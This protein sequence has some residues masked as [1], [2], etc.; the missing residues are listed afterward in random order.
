MFD[1]FALSLSHTSALTKRSRGSVLWYLA[2][3]RFPVLLLHQQAT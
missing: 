2:R 1:H 3:S